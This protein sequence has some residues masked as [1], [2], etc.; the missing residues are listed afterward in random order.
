M[1]RLRKDFS[2]RSN[3]TLS[4]FC[5]VSM[6]CWI[7]WEIGN[8]YFFLNFVIGL[9]TYKKFVSDQ[10]RIFTFTRKMS[11]ENSRKHIYSGRD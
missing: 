9:K 10:I 1:L 7:T 11:Q 2:F 8:L 4:L 6:F 3:L 5:L